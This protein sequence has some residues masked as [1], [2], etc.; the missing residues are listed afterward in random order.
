[1][2]DFLLISI[3]YDN[4]KIE[5]KRILNIFHSL[6]LPISKEKLEGPTQKIT[7][8]GIGID[9]SNWTIFLDNDRVQHLQKI[10][11]VWSCHTN[12]K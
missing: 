4:A 11:S 2:D 9:V 7:F 8:L 5:L 10:F 3:G 1:M 6:G 12:T